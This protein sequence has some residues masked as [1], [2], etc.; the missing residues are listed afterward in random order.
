MIYFQQFSAVL[1][2]TD[3]RL[4]HSCFNLINE[5]FIRCWPARNEAY[6]MG[7]LR[8]I[9]DKFNLFIYFKLASQ[10]LILSLKEQINPEEFKLKV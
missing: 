1:V 2:P 10:P 9:R 7:L 8:S 6:Q 3:A 5:K 4:F